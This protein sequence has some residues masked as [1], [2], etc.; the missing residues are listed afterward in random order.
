MSFQHIDRSRA[1]A[2]RHIEAIQPR[3]NQFCLALGL[4]PI[5]LKTVWM[6]GERFVIR[7][8]FK[9]AF[10]EHAR[11]EGLP[12]DLDDKYCRCDLSSKKINP[13]CN[14]CNFRKWR[15][16]ITQAFGRRY[17]ERMKLLKHKYKWAQDHDNYYSTYTGRIS[18]ADC[19]PLYR[20][21]RRMEFTQCLLDLTLEAQAV[22]KEGWA[23]NRI[24]FPLLPDFTT[25]NKQTN[26][27]GTNKVRPILAKS[28]P[29]VIR[30][31]LSDNTILFTSSFSL[32]AQDMIHF[33]R[34]AW[35]SQRLQEMVIFAEDD[36][37]GWHFEFIPYRPYESEHETAVEIARELYR[38][39][40]SSR[41]ELVLINS[42]I[43]TFNF[44]LGS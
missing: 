6:V 27:R 14:P 15:R 19:W 35:Y 36:N 37:I 7:P 26:Y 25:M 10:R 39:S 2:Q 16:K 44:P 22:V 33:G 1:E 38:G 41:V 17:G 20:E 40:V 42:S 11:E 5:A 31:W 43:L 24:P 23:L 4:K 32:P 12:I 28:L 9:Q 8:A 3:F 21:G 18:D 13:N 30:N 34:Y 29:T